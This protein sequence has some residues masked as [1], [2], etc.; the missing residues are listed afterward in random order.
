VASA[1]S[2]S[3]CFGSALAISV[4]ARSVLAKLVRAKFVA[5]RLVRL[6]GAS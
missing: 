3:P 6:I 1:I 2:R 4:I 5:A